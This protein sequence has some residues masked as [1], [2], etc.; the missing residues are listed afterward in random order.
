VTHPAFERAGQPGGVERPIR[1]SVDE[2]AG[3]AYAMKINRTELAAIAL[4]TPI[5]AMPRAT[6]SGGPTAQIGPICG[7]A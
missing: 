7:R 2:G 1:D 6:A 4:A 3:S 5:P